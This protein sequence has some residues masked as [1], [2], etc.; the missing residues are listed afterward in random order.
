M[1]EADAAVVLLLTQMNQDFA[2]LLVE[3][4]KSPSDPWSGQIAFPGGKRD[5]KDLSLKQTVIRETAEETNIDLTRNCRFL[6]VLE[7]IRSTAKPEMVVTPFVVLI[8]DEPSIMLNEELVRYFWIS[9][10]ALQKHKGIAKFSFGEVSAYI[11]KEKVIWGLTYRILEEFTKILEQ[12][13]TQ[14]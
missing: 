6:G 9:V 2:T 14:C 1:I 7:N 3:R 12:A 8:E 13:S 4:T 10:Q 11:I 5:S